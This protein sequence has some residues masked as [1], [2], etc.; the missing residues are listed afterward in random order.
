M[1]IRVEVELSELEYALDELERFREE[2]M[3][4][5]KVKK[6]YDRLVAMTD[7][8]LKPERDIK[9]SEHGPVQRLQELVVETKKDANGGN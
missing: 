8:I 4:L 3:E 5:R 6:D 2:V 1:K 9:G 7:I